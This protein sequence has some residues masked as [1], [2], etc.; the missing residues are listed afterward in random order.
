[1]S[2]HYHSIF[3]YLDKQPAL[4]TNAYDFKEIAMADG[5]VVFTAAACHA[6][7]PGFVSPCPGPDLKGYRE[8][9]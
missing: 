8:S 9:Y 4:K 3:Q 7:N 5:R 2:S 6:F 1:M